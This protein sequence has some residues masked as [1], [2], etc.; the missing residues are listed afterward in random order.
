ESGIR[1]D[2][3]VV[4]HVYA[5]GGDGGLFW[6]FPPKIEPF[7]IVVEDSVGIGRAF[8]GGVANFLPREEEPVV[9]RRCHLWALDWWGDAAGAYVRAENAAMRDAAD[10]TF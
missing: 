7:T 6:D 5:T 9:F 3:W 4:R 2:R 10:V 8:G 1:W